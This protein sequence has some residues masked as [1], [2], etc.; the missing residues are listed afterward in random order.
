MTLDRNHSMTRNQDGTTIDNVT[1]EMK[2]V[3]ELMASNY[4]KDEPEPKD[5]EKSP[6]F[7]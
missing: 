2:N 6:F 5:K 3:I 7:A 1:P 4:K